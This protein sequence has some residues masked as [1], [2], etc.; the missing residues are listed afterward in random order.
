MKQVRRRSRA[1]WVAIC[2]AYAASDETAAA[3][4]KQR[5]LNRGTFDWWCGIFRKEGLLESESKATF[6]EVIGDKQPKVPEVVIRIGG[7]TVELSGGLPPIEWIA[8][9]AFRC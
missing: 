4:A 6:V 1:E 2:E 5:G 9:L 8:E 7:V 3:F